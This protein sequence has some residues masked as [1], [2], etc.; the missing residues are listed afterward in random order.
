MSSIDQSRFVMP[1]SIAGVSGAGMR[2]ALSAMLVE[3]SRNDCKPAE[4]AGIFVFG[5]GCVLL[6]GH[7]LI[8]YCHGNLK[9]T[10]RKKLFLVLGNANRH[11]HSLPLEERPTLNVFVAA[12]GATGESKREINDDSTAWNSAHVG[13]D[14][15]DIDGSGLDLRR[16][17]LSFINS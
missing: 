17:Y 3:V 1:A 12:L 14:N 9:A 5:F 13:H 16:H 7:S 6:I 8:A 11:C 2:S 10:C 15:R 4:N